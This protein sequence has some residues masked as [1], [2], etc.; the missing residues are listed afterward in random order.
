MYC[1]KGA[2]SRIVKILPQTY[3][4]GC[5]DYSFAVAPFSRSLCQ[6]KSKRRIGTQQALNNHTVETREID[7]LL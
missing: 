2:Q 1:P 7:V 4:R 5:S 3:E 6:R